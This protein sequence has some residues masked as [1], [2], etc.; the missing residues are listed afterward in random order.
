M[1]FLLAL[2]HRWI[3]LLTCVLLTQAFSAQ[4]HDDDKKKPPTR[5]KA[6]IAAARLQMD[7]AKKKLSETG[8][9]SCC[10]KAPPGSKVAGCDMCAKMNG[11]CNCGANI[12]QGKG[13]CGDCLAGWKTGRGAFP[14]VDKEKVTLLDSSHQGM[15]GMDM[16]TALQELSQAQ[17]TLN[18]A[19]RTLVEEK[20]YSCCIG[21]AG[22]D[23]CAYEA[24]CPC[25]KELAKG[26]KSSGICGQCY[27]GQHAGIGRIQGIDM[28]AIK[29]NPM[30]EG[31]EGMGQD[32]FAGIPMQRG[33]SGTSWQP[34]STPMHAEHRQSGLWRVM[35][36]YN[37][38]LSY[39]YQSGPRGGDQINGIGWYMVMA[40]R[41]VGRGE[42]MLRTMLSPEPATVGARGYPLLLQSGEAYHGQPL[43]DRQ[44]PHDFLMEVAARYR[45]A[46]DEKTAAFLYAAPSGEPALG[47]TAF[48]HRMS[49]INNP[50]APISHHWQDSSHITFG[51][52]TAGVSRGNWQADGSFF[53]GREPDEKRWDIDPIRFNSYSG[54]LTYNPGPN[55]SFQGSYGY[56]KSPEALRPAED[57][58]RTTFS[59]AYN[60]PLADGG[61]WASTFVWGRNNH[62][63]SNSDSLLLE[64]DYNIADKNTL[65]G[66]I[67]HVEKLGDDLALVPTGKKFPLTELTLGGIHELTPDKP[68]QTGVGA[69]VTFNWTPNDLKALYGG[70]PVGFWLFLRI[71]PA[72]MHMGGHGG[73]MEMKE[74][75]A[76]KKE[77]M[78]KPAMGKMKQ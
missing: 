10:V 18:K 15:P 61:N 35:Q 74:M 16:T 40:S 14:G 28:A 31:M 4:A 49:A 36:H 58:R 54:R 42:L 55:W 37:G 51:V 34:D 22:C 63:G 43:V 68:Y 70:S 19:K 8:R 60:R 77:D 47:P 62:G 24:S 48:P 57:L 27:D 23:E 30:Q 3:L 5:A 12:A 26:Q 6:D 21:H 41:P 44:H 69:A 64:T 9:Y 32:A 46:L 59:A 29:L 75:G 20:R 66:R 73:E 52:L 11:S 56:L 7:A 33:A 25:A 72:A 76:A 2:R 71:R 39:D 38:F 53:N 78:K 1:K 67:E 13:V 65:F 45:Y 50:L 17:Q